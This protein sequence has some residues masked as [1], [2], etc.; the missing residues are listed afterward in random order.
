[1]DAKYRAFVDALN[2]ATD[3]DIAKSYAILMGMR[4]RSVSEASAPPDPRDAELA[5]LRAE[6]ERLNET[7]QIMA[8]CG[9]SPHWVGKS[10]IP[11]AIRKLARAA[12][13]A[14]S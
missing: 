13:G 6:V 12:L 9:M 14:G 10:D 2:N 8:D 5:R 7:L 11:A 4:W 1:M 3:A